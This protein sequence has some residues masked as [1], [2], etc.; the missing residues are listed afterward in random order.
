MT[1]IA[2]DNLES[3]AVRVL[4]IDDQMIFA[5]LIRRMLV[6]IDNV[7][8]FY[9]SNPQEAVNSAIEVDATAILLDLNMPEV[10]GFEVLTW[11]R[12]DERTQRIPV[13]MLSSED[14]PEIKQEAFAHHANDYL[15][16][17]PERTEMVAR[18]RAHSRAYLN[19]LALDK[20]LEENQA[21]ATKLAEANDRLRAANKD[22]QQQ[23]TTDALTGIANRRLFDSC[24]NNETGRLKRSHEHLSLLLLDID[25]F[26]KF[27]DTYGHQA[28]D[29]CLQQVGQLLSEIINR[30][31]DLP[32]RYGGEEFAIVLPGTDKRGARTIA[33]QVCKA[34][35]A[36]EIEHSAS[37]VADHVTVSIGL[38]SIT[39]PGDFDMDDLIKKADEKL[40]AAKQRGRN[41][42]C[43]SI[44]EAL[45]N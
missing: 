45:A 21:L 25:Y 42:V 22:L 16:K 12:A 44:Q 14:R 17:N 11:L 32:A 34:V 7:S 2:P 38:A 33:E 15:V 6:D 3:V 10:N 1:E 41:Q 35:H 36:L 5:E 20:T 37:E 30:E 13:I 43:C 18:L 39:G 8:F 31:T 28:G 26:K 29:E 23:S 27:N 4:L 19:M 9:T 24:L 40:Y